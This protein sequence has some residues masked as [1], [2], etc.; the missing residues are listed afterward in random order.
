MRVEKRELVW[1]GNIDSGDEN[2][3]RPFLLPGVRVQFE[4]IGRKAFRA[5]NRVCVEVYRQNPDDIEDAGDALSDELL[6]RGIKAWEGIGGPGSADD[7]DLPVTPENIEMVIA[8]PLFFAAADFA[9]VAPFVARQREGNVSAPSPSGTGAGEM[10][11][12]DIASSPA[13]PPK[14]ADASPTM[15]AMDVRTSPTSR[16]P[17]KARK[18]GS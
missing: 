8:D 11:A 13:A 12:D 18:S 7:E 6:R 14:T 9:Y 10:P 1:L 2:D 16:R 5:A 4:P 3:P 15:T 17:R